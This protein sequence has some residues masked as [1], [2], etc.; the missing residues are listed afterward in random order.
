MERRVHRPYDWDQ[1]GE[2][3]GYDS[4]VFVWGVRW[5]G[6]YPGLT[7][8]ERSATANGWSER[9][10]RPMHEIRIETNVFSLNLVFHDVVIAKLRDDVPIL[11]R[12]NIPTNP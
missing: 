4:S 3:E 5:A 1:D 10:G 6:A 2:P 7:Y 12:V 8:L 11:D 9:L